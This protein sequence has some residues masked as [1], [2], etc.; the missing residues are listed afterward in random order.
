MPPSRLLVLFALLSA[1]AHA[2]WLN[3]PTPGTPRTRDGQPNL[4]APAPRA[5]NGK[6]E[7]SGMWQVESSPIPDL[8][9]LPS[10]LPGGAN[11]LGETPP[12]KYFINIL[13]DFKPDEAPLQPAA[14][15]RFRD[16]P[17]VTAG[18]EFPIA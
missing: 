16:K 18:K 5:P 7:L 10:Q 17:L 2:Q 11:G 12:S 6:P 14:A 13:S 1:G 15:A 4:S 9:R 3:F 8:T